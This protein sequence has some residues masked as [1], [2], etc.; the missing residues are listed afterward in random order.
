MGAIGEQISMAWSAEQD[1]QRIQATSDRRAALST[2]LMV[3]A[4]SELVGHFVLGAAHSMAN[5][6]LRVLL[7]NSDAAGYLEARYKV[8]FHPGSDE[9]SVWPTFNESMTKRLHGAAELAGQPEL[10]VLADVISGL[11]ESPEFQGLDGRRGMDYHRRRP[12]SVAHTAPREGV[13]TTENGSTRLRMAGARVD[14]DAD[15]IVVHGVAVA[16]LER[17]AFAM[18]Q[19]RRSV[20]AAMRA[21][22]INYPYDFVEEVASES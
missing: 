18:N 14:G 10:V 7:L 1:V 12:Q 15:P 19:F 11:R 4:T 8:K 13:V 9:R 16:A 17:V 22:G 3:R 2:T 5:A 21:Q 6:A 20:P